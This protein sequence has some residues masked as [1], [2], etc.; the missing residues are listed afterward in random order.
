[1]YLRAI[2]YSSIQIHYFRNVLGDDKGKKYYIN[3]WYYPER[4]YGSVDLPEEFQAEVQFTL[5]DGERLEVMS[6]LQR[7]C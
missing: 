1:M 2:S 5:Q 4:F 6:F 3:A 7:Y